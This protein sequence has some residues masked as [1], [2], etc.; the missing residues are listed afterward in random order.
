LKIK[1]SADIEEKLAIPTLGEIGHV[2]N[3]EQKNN[4]H[5]LLLTSS[6]LPASYMEAYKMLDVIIRYTTNTSQLKKLMITS[7]LESEGKTLVSI[8]LGTAL[9][10]SGKSVLLIDCDLRKSSVHK[11]LGITRSNLGDNNLYNALKNHDDLNKCIIRMQSGLAVLPFINP[12]GVFKNIFES[13]AFHKAITL[14]AQRYDYILFDT[15]PASKVTDTINLVS[16]VD[17]IILVIRQEQAPVSVVSDTITTLRKVGGNII[18]SVLNDVRHHG[19]GSTYYS[20]YKYYY[21]NKYELEKGDAVKASD[22]DDEEAP[23]PI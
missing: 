21:N 14:L 11:K 17:G 13:S 19:I 9:A 2:A 22:A 1:N 6:Q 15:A 5:A 8:N 3:T 4:K 10:N 20:K 7:A 12:P 16:C 18:G 23:V